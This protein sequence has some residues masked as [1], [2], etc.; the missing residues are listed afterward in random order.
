MDIIYKLNKLDD[1]IIN[2]IYSFLGMHPVANI[3]NDA[4]KKAE[5]DMIDEY[6]DRLYEEY[7]DVYCAFLCLVATRVGLFLFI[8]SFTPQLLMIW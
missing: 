6:F 5:H 7:L 2:N 1:G 4:L 3:L 8:N